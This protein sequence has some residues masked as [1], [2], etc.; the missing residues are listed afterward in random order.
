MGLADPVRRHAKGAVW[1]DRRRRGPGGAPAVVSGWNGERGGLRL[2]L[3]PD[4]PESNG[5][6][7]PHAGVDAVGRLGRRRA[8]AADAH[9]PRRAHARDAAVNA[10]AARRADGALADGREAR[11]SP[12]GRVGTHAGR[13]AASGAEE[14]LRAHRR[15]GRVAGAEPARGTSQAAGLPG[16][17]LVGPGRAAAGD[18]GGHRAGGAVCTDVA[19]ASRRAAGL[20]RRR[21]V[22]AVGAR[23]ASRAEAACGRARGREGYRR[24]ATAVVARAAEARSV[25]GVGVGA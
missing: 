25:M 18:R 2:Q 13:S 24:A 9:V 16:A 4:P 20:Q 12:V 5:T 15:A 7:V 1:T 6:R 21:R 8:A 22:A 10:V 3:A 17:R 14:A 23:V 19:R 11:H